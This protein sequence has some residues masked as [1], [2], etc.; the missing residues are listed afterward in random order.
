MQPCASRSPP[1]SGA[2]L[3]V[4][5]VPVFGEELLLVAERI[6]LVINAAI[7]KTTMPRRR[8]VFFIGERGYQL[9][10]YRSQQLRLPS[11]L[12]LQSSMFPLTLRKE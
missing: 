6:A 1:T 10:P 7:A 12:L 11:G 8:E 2:E 4:S 9:H 5:V 3:E